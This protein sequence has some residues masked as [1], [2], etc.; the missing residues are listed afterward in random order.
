MCS[1]S[2]APIKVKCGWEKSNNR[3][4]NKREKFHILHILAKNSGLGCGAKVGIKAYIKVADSGI[5]KR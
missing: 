2:H 5:K 3:E 4:R 1:S